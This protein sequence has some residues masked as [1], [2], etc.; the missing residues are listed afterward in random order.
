MRSVIS[1]LDSDSLKAF[2]AASVEIL[3]PLIPNIK[4]LSFLRSEVYFLSNLLI[5]LF[6]K[7]GTPLY[8]P[9]LIKDSGILRQNRP[10]RLQVVWP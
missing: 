7:T 8:S 1:C 10:H 2:E 6:S 3:F 4:L 9:L 5:K